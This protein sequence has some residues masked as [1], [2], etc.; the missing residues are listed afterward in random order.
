MEAA[1]GTLDAD[2]Q[3]RL[4]AQIV[5]L[6][7]ASFGTDAQLAL[8]VMR[9]IGIGEHRHLA[10]YSMGTV[11][12]ESLAWMFRTAAQH[13]PESTMRALSIEDEPVVAQ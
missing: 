12:E 6:V 4:M 9:E 7:R 11:T 5:Q 2:G 10:V 13:L 3:R 8:T 1:P